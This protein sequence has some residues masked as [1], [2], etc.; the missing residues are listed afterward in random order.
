LI[1]LFIIS[2]NLIIGG[3]PEPKTLIYSNKILKLN[4]GFGIKIKSI[5]LI[6]LFLITF[7]VSS[8]INIVGSF[9]SQKNDVTRVLSEIEVISSDNVLVDFKSVDTL[10]WREFGGVRI[11]LDW[12]FVFSE[13]AI[14]EY[15][16]RWEMLC[17]KNI[18]INCNYDLFKKNPSEL[19]DFLSRNKIDKI[20]ISKESGL[21]L[22]AAYFDKI[23]ENVDL[24]SY[25]PKTN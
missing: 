8:Y 20:I 13:Q 17:G 4:I 16:K 6:I 1:T 3:E 19:V 11:W 24:I 12:Y 25:K 10:G 18:I 14:L 2:A 5:Y 15:G 9:N 21:T 7:L 22:S 23:G